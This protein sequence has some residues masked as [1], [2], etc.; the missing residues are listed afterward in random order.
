MNRL[1][2]VSFLS[3]ITAACSNGNA[4]APPPGTAMTPVAVRV[5][6]VAIEVVAR[7]VIA[8]GTVGPKEEVS[9][10][11][12]VGGVIGRVLVDEGQVVRSGDTLAVLD[13]SEIDAAVTLARSA[14]EKAERDLARAQ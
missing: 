3:L 2:L 11:F 12:K 14:A 1:A 9:L 6:P 13:L 4:K 10:S 7:P 8:T 5:V